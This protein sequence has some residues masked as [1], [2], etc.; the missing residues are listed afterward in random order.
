MR[1][2][3]DGV[4]DAGHGVNTHG[5]A[6]FLPMV[7]CNMVSQYTFQVGSYIGVHWLY[8]PRGLGDKVSIHKGCYV[9]V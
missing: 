7:L 5:S 8:A 9:I 6:T 3:M 2:A 4:V 1:E